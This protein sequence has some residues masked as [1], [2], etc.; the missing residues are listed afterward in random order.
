MPRR[1]P[2]R[3]LQKTVKAGGCQ[4]YEINASPDKT[5]DR[6][7][8]SG[9]RYQFTSGLDLSDLT[10][11]LELWCDRNIENG[12]TAFIKAGR[13]IRT[14]ADGSEACH[15]SAVTKGP[16]KASRAR[17][18]PSPDTPRHNTNT[19]NFHVIEPQNSGAAH[20]AK[21]DVA[22]ASVNRLRASSGGPV[23]Q[24][25]TVGA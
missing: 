8:N 2:R 6:G 5:L 11:M 9:L 24:A 13:T 15:S 19:T 21:P 18:A 7:S 12:E 14:R 25:V 20:A 3:L 17:Y 1:P 16:K 4:N 10:R 22:H 23:P